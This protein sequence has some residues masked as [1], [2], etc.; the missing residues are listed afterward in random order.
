MKDEL[1]QSIKQAVKHWWVPVL[2]GVLALVLGIWSLVTP[3][4]TLVALTYV[5]VCVFIISG[6]FEIIFSV[7][8]KDILNDWGWTLAGGI[9]DLLFGIILLLLPPAA[10]TMILIY[11][12]GFWIMFRGIW[13]IGESFELKRMGVQGWG[14]F[15]ALAILT[16]IFSFVFIVSPLISS[17][18]IVA[19]ISVAFLFYGVSRIY[20]GVKLR[21]LHKTLKQ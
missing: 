12:V 9:I 11:F 4:V 6:L 16:I 18:F 10:V 7:A 20:L 3:D 1:F 15:L 19:F 8:N 13:I 5:F 17:I 2:V 14:W 21:S